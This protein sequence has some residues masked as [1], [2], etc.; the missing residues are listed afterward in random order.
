L[1]ALTAV[2]AADYCRDDIDTCREQNRLGSNKQRDF[3]SPGKMACPALQ[4]A[5]AKA[6]Q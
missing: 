5:I 1:E 4:L 2:L 6:R 3:A